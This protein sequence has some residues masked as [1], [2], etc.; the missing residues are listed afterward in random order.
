MSLLLRGAFADFVAA[1]IDLILVTT[2]R[3][4]PEDPD[5]RTICDIDLVSFGC[6]W[7]RYMHDSTNLKAEFPGP[8]EEYRWKKR[9]FLETVLNRP[10]IFLTDFFHERYEGRARENI[11]RLIDLINRGQD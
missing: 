3:D 2:H 9:A 10:R 7:E 6:P 5:Q 1:V 4:P 11:P 8:E